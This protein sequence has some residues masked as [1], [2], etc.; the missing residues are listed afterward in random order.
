MPRRYREELYGLNFKEV[1]KL[2]VGGPIT[3]KAL[4]DGDIQVG[5]LF[6]GSSVIDPDFVLLQDDKLLQPADNGSG[7]A[8]VGRQHRAAGRDRLGEREAHRRGVQQAQSSG[9][10]RREARPRGRGV[11]VVEGSRAGLGGAERAVAMSAE[12]LDH[13]LRVSIGSLLPKLRS[14]RRRQRS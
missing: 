10:W 9:E 12:S 8:V 6:T 1:K 11:A 4:K 5:L 3:V 7:V 14:A 2:D 13:A